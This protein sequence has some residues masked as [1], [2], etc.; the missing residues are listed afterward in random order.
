MPDTASDLVARARLA[1]RERRFGDARSDLQI[2]IDLLQDDGSHGELADALRS[3]G[4]VERRLRKPDA[5]RAHYEEAV[6]LYRDLD[7][8]NTLAH[9]IRHLGDVHSDSGRFDLASPCY[10]EALSIYLSHGDAPPLDL[11]NAIRSFA[12]LN[13]RTGN[14]DQARQLWAEA[15][16]LYKSVDVSDGV[17]ECARR[18]AALNAA[19][20][21]E[22]ETLGFAGGEENT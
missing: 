10:R 1:A 21:A 12:L 18:L 13:E 14:R 8:P 17:A 19:P 4:E 2:A 20:P 6:A 7:D 15:A 11:A 16:E 3:L 22:G 9:T 5:A